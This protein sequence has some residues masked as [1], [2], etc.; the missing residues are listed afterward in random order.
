MTVATLLP[1]NASPLERS[2]EQAMAPY[3]DERE[4]FVDKLWRPFECPIEVLPFLA[5]A[6]GVRRWDP[7]WP[8]AVRRQAVADAIAVHR[9]RGT[10]GAV[11]AALDEVGAVYDI[12]E[13][14]GGADFTMAVS[15]YNS[16]TLLGETDVAA[17][18]EYIDDV[19]RF[20]VHYD[21]ALAAS[22]DCSPI[23]IMAGVGGV[24]IGDFRLEVDVAEN[25]AAT[26][27]PAIAGHARVG[28]ELTASAGSIADADGL[29]NAAYSWQWRRDGV[30][31]AGATGATYTLVAADV[32]ARIGVT[33][34]FTDDAGYAERRTSA[35]TGPVLGQ[36]ALAE[37]TGAGL[38]THAAIVIRVEVDGEHLYRHADAG[39]AIGALLDGNDA[40]G[41]SR[42]TRV[43]RLAGSVRLHD[44][45][46]ADSMRTV[47]DALTTPRL[48]VQTETALVSAPYQRAGGNFANFSPIDQAAALVID[49]LAD[50]DRVIVAVAS[51]S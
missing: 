18:R 49:A 39:A 1:P 14:P 11:E 45:P 6:L 13:R 23:H 40:L 20:S 41:A 7:A 9:I 31:I 27:A 44:N 51:P 16:N 28:Y 37:W 29:Q 19:K 38:T 46:D 12:E 42:I 30:E 26:G 25:A 21:L 36:L 15:V 22:L 3:G 4:V 17:L 43:R 10:L 35:E 50:N 2:F 47:L 48:Y 8:E 5:W 32:G 33:A 24:Q 34:H